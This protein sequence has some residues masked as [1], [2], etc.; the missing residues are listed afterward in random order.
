MNPRPSGVVRS[1]YCLSRLLAR[2]ACQPAWRI[3]ISSGLVRL[4]GAM[5]RQGE[6][7]AALAAARDGLKV[8]ESTGCGHWDAELHRLDGIALLGLNRIQE[9]QAALKEALR[10]AQRQQA[11]SYELR[12][13]MSIAQLWGEQGRRTEACELLAPIHGCFT[14]GFETVDL[15]NA[16]ALLDALA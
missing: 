1:R 2:G 12:A 11:K 6:H 16:K 4:A 14:E 3:D 13:A 15:K 5:A 7:G 8:E 10:V 9:S